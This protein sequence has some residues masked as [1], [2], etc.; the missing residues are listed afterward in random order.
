MKLEKS[1][2]LELFKNMI[3][4]GLFLDVDVTFN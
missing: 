1:L 2:N 3:K 4:L